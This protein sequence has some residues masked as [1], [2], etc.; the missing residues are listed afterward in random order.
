MRDSLDISIEPKKM[1]GLT[2]K[3]SSF[4][5]KAISQQSVEVKDTK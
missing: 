2:S 5:P 3:Y 1:L 4:R